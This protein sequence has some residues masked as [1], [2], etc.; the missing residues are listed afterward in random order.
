MA[1]S[2]TVLETADGSELGKVFGGN[3]LTPQAF[4]VASLFNVTEEPVSDLQSLSKVLQRLENDPTRTII[5][6]SIVEGKTNP[7]PRNKA[8]FTSI[9]RQWCMIVS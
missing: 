3:E 5:R 4:R 2:I 7:V 9:P 6:G 1:D 8:T